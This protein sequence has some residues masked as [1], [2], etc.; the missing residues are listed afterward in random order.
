MW[1]IG[2]VL[3]L[4]AGSWAQFFISATRGTPVGFWLTPIFGLIVPAVLVYFFGWWML[5]SFFF[6]CL[7]GGRAFM[8][9][10][11]RRQEE[12]KAEILREHEEYVRRHRGNGVRR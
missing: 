7:I 11:Y 2:N 8:A 4:L 12:A 10:A 1:W 5:L 6:G 3:A 9:Y